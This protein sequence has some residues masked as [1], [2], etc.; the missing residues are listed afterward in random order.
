MMKVDCV[1]SEMNFMIVL[2][3]N[4]TTEKPPPHNAGTPFYI[5]E[6]DIG[7]L[8]QYI[9]SQGFV[10]EEVRTNH[11][12]VWKSLKRPEHFI[13]DVDCDIDSEVRDLVEYVKSLRT[14][15]GDMPVPYHITLFS[16]GGS[17]DTAPPV[18][19]DD[20]QKAIMDFDGTEDTMISNVRVTH[21]R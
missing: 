7:E 12:K 11:L 14:H 13:L 16:R 20:I 19:K 9:N 15:L 18:L 1:D 6:E 2:M 3:D 21:R 4:T 5:N 17:W 8:E 10:G